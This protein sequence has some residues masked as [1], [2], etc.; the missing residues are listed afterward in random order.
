VFGDCLG[1]AAV[2][3][4]LEGKHVVIWTDRN[5]L[6][7]VLNFSDAQRRLTRW[8]LRLLEFYF[9]V[10]YATGKEH[11]GADTLSRLRPS[12][13]SLVEP[14]TAVDTEIPCFELSWSTLRYPPPVVDSQTAQHE[15]TTPVLLYKF[16]LYKKR[17]PPVASWRYKTPPTWTAILMASSASCSRM[18]NFE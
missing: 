5:S 16:L 8:R 15:T 1:S 14:P 10:Q 4:Y 6:R 17:I 3:T 12:D 2:E 9:E 18:E 13:P 7:W 11:H